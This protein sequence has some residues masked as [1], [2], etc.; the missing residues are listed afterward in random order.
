MIPEPPKPKRRI[1]RPVKTVLVV[2]GVVVALCC[3][4]TVTAG[5]FVGYDLYRAP[6]AEAEIRE[7]ADKLARHLESGDHEAVYDMLS[8]D[9]RR[10]CPLEILARGLA[11]RPRPGGHEI[12][13][14]YALLWLSYVT[15]RLYYRDGTYPGI[16]TFD[17]VE[18]DGTWKVASD[19]LH[20]LD[21][22]PRHGGHGG[23]G[24]D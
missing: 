2:L 6:R 20:D 13:R 16:H 1:R 23:H 22:G 21:T 11:D 5:A 17:L 9:A 7:F 8:A 19:L 3:L 18:E 10:R 4:G 12:D 15:I 24:G 14:A